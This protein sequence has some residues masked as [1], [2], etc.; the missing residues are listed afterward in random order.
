MLLTLA[1]R[2]LRTLI[3]REDG[4]ALTLFDLPEFAIKQLLLRGLNVEASMLAGRSLQDLDQLRDRADKAACPFLVLV[5]ENPLPF[6]AADPER[7]EAAADRVER[8]A[9]ASNRLG[10]NALALRCEAADDDDAFDLTAAQIKAL[11][12]SVERQE[13]NVL[14]SPNEGLTESPERL[15]DLIKRIGGWRIGSLPNFAHAAATG[16]PVETLRKLAPYAGVVHATVE[17]FNKKGSHLGYDLAECVSA[18]RSVGF[19]NTLAI[20]YVGNGDPVAN[21][22]RAREILQQ[23]IDAPE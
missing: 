23:A 15:T 5:E 12:P 6:A 22:D 8:L 4:D 7:R 16:E 10:C 13:L 11:M 1:T 17:G 9:I 3:S 20:D 2:S 14:I 19:L 21:I 18:I